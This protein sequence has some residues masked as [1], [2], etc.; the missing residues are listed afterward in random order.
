MLVGYGLGWGIRGSAWGTVLAQLVEGAGFALVV[1]STARRAGAELTARGG[2]VRQG[3]VVGGPLVVR[4]ASLVTV[5]VA[6]TALAA[7]IGDR[8]V[9]AHQIAYQVLLF[10]AFALDALAIAGQAMIGRLLGAADAA[11]ARAAARRM[12]EWGV[13]AGIGFAVVVLSARLEIAAVFTSVAGVR[14]LVAE[15]LVFVALL[16]PLNAI[17]FVLDGVLIG[18]GDQRYL[19]AAMLAATLGVFAPAAVAVAASGAGILVLW[20]ALVAWFAARGFGVGL[21]YL[22]S[23]WQVTGPR[24]ARGLTSSRTAA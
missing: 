13:L 3:A 17:V 22:G 23:G 7:R 4:T 6:A 8:D 19:A 5:T 14:R 24:R 9:A 18:A 15:L 20:S 12:L 16:Q 10:L 1:A 11:Q 21:R 2:G